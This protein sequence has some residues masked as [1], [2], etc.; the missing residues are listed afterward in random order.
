MS[1]PV[2]FEG[3]RSR[4][5][6]PLNSS[7]RELVVACLRALYQRLHSPSADQHQNLTRE[8]LRELLLPVVREYQD[9]VVTDA[10]ADEFNTPEANDPQQ[11]TSVV[12][13]VLLA[14][15]WL[16]VFGDRHGLV[17]AYRFSRPGKL[18]AEAIWSLDRPSRSRQRNMRGCRNA[19]DAALDEK[20]DAHDI[21]DAFEYAENVIKDLSEGIDYFQE[22][23]RSLMQN[24]TLH[25][26]WTEFVEFLDRFQ[27][28]YSRQ[29]T[30]DNA[31]LNRQAIRQK[32]EKLRMVPEA[33]FRRMDA[34]LH[35]IAHW[36]KAEYHGDSLYDWM[37]DLIEDKV[38]AA[39]ESKQPGFLKAMETYLKRVNGL[40]LQS[41]MLH[42]GQ[43]RHAYL[44]AIQKVAGFS[45]A[46]QDRL[47][48]AIGERIAAAEVRLLDPSSFKLRT[49]SQRRK[50]VTVSIRPRPSREER[51]A[52]AMTRAES[53]AFSIPN[54]EIAQ[55]LRSDL[56]L[57][58]HPM[59]LSTLPTRTARDVTRAMQAVEA[60][61]SDAG[62]DLQVRKLPLR[63]END[64]Y[65]GSDY[66]FQLKQ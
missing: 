40:V 52:A 31:T 9:K 5:F 10:A 15:G 33:K 51:L 17:N 49:S 59:R 24:A 20:G 61:R 13:R 50:A 26:E 44:A 66:E 62:G 36:A 2:F 58:K 60:A 55:A 47:L 27:R 4:F 56:R 18:F 25:T 11:L 37:L 29:L 63:L 12:V 43:S 54:E 38:D 42:A 28:D 30:S 35:D 14:D 39:C 41:M 65:I 16:E 32:L 19:L 1:V 57:F 21:V 34:Q 22:L 45:P 46:D 6:R 53:E 7:R 64:S 48:E 3:D 8:L 23:V